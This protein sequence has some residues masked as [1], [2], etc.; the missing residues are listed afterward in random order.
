MIKHKVDMWGLLLRY[1]V[2]GGIRIPPGPGGTGKCMGLP[3]SVEKEPWLENVSQRENIYF[4]LLQ[5]T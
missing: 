4:S 1:N 3:I 2:C 5:M